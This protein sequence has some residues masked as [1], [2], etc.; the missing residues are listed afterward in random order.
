MSCSEKRMGLYV[1]LKHALDERDAFLY[2]DLFA[3]SSGLWIPL[4]IGLVVPNS[5]IAEALYNLLSTAGIYIFSIAFLASSSSFLYLERRKN[6]VNIARESYDRRA[7]L[8][9]VTLLFFGMFFIGIQ[10]SNISPRISGS[11][12]EFPWYWIVLQ[13]IY[14]LLSVWMGVRLFCLRNIEKIPGELDQI[15]ENDRKHRDELMKE[16]QKNDS[17]E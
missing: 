1:A 14:L 16:A 9:T 15:R 7:L 5:K 11:F 2:F 4:I 13:L 8:K 3:G 17:F 6:S 12:H 10:L